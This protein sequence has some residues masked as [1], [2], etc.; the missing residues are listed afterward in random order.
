MPGSEDS[1]RRQLA[2]LAPQRYPWRFNGPR[3][4]AHR[5]ENRLFVPFNKLSVALEGI[6]VFNPYPPRRF[7]LIHAFNRIPISTLPFVIGFESHLP[8]AAGT[9]AN[10]IM[11]M[12]LDALAHDRCRRIVAIS[13]AARKLFRKAHQGWRHFDRLERKLTVRYPNFPVP[14]T[15]DRL[16]G[17][18]VAAIRLVFVG[19]HFGRK[20]GCVAVKIAELA[21][22]RGLP[23]Q[24]DIVSML[25]CGGG[26]WTDPPDR[27]FFRP[28]LALLDLPNVTHHRQLPN[29]A[30][31]DLLR[32]AHLSILTTFSDTFG[33]SAIESMANFAPVIATDQGALPEFIVD[34][35]NGVLL[36]LPVNEEREWLGTKAPDRSTPQFAATYRDEVQRLAESAFA[37][38][39]DLQALPQRLFEMR[40]QSRLTAARQF[41]A[42]DAN[43]YWDGVYDAAF[44]GSRT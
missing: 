36:D 26:I 11:R 14:E 25:E 10:V 42:E 8:R 13:E 9:D 18:P 24:V 32:S 34:G 40:R 4:S 6:T 35:I 12:Q 43:T 31:L 1:T 30:I 33:Y 23:V 20:G 3:K 22:K 5:I 38:I 19:N 2:I 27:E 37:A 39:A 44:A 17:Q 29:A 28:Y 41:S 21:L 16:A 7:D 15:E